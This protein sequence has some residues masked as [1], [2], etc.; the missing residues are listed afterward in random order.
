MM[1]GERL[2]VSVYV[3]DLIIT[4]AQEEDINGFKHEM[5]ARFHMSDLVLLSYYLDIKVKQGRD[6]ITLCQRAYVGKLLE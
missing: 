1:G 4:E 2:I 6:S 3:D 5:K